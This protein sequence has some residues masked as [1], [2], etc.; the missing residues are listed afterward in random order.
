MRRANIPP[1]PLTQVAVLRGT[2]AT[3]TPRTS[4]LPRQVVA[5]DSMKYSERAMCLGFFGAPTTIAEQLS[6]GKECIYAM[7]PLARLAGLEPIIAAVEIGGMN[8]L[9]PILQAYHAGKPC[10]DVDL[11]GRAFPRVDMTSLALYGKQDPPITLVR[12]GLLPSPQP[13]A[14][15]PAPAP[16]SVWIQHPNLT[17]GGRSTFCSA[18]T[19]NMGG[20]G[21]NCKVP[22]TPC[23]STP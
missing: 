22:R 19:N 9:I 11:M 2:G 23:V 16:H 3:A 6:N 13:Q 21:G 5:A 10:L 1:M 4:R 20:G 14:P 18:N 17:K 15:A 7:E 12:L 8:S